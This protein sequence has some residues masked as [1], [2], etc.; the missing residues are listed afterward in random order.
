MTGTDRLFYVNT[1]AMCR[2]AVST[3]I[4]IVPTTWITGMILCYAPYHSPAIVSMEEVH[5]E[6]YKELQ[7][8][9]DAFT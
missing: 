7:E 3:F 9:A 1:H 4:R 2:T 8:I 5:P 6:L